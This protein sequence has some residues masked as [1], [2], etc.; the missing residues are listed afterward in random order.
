MLYIRYIAIISKAAYFLSS[1]LKEGRLLK[2]SFRFWQSLSV[3]HH[4]AW[5]AIT[6]PSNYWQQLCNIVNGWKG[7]KWGLGHPSIPLRPTPCSTAG[8]WLCVAGETERMWRRS[9]WPFALVSL[10][11]WQH[12]QPCGQ[13]AR[14]C[15]LIILAQMIR[16]NYLPGHYCV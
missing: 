1:G 9:V 15:N 3:G 2:V 14:Q 16:G 12:S 13:S 7:P 10:A 11:Q 6:G 4:L 5:W 8:Q